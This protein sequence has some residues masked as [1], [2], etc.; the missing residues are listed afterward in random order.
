M[1]K[2][3]LPAL[4][5]CLMLATAALERLELARYGLQLNEEVLVV[6][7]EVALAWLLRLADLMG[8]TGAGDRLRL[9][10]DRAVRRGSVWAT[11]AIAAGPY[12]WTAWTVRARRPTSSPTASFT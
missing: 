10:Q 6:F 5:G 1:T 3:F 12:R 4:A 11:V 7:N 8:P 2:I 9:R